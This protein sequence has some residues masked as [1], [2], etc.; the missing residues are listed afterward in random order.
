MTYNLYK[1]NKTKNVD[2]SS[3]LDTSQVFNKVVRTKLAI[4]KTGWEI[5]IINYAFV[6]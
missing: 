1:V 6:S 5:P 3:L 4:A 2:A